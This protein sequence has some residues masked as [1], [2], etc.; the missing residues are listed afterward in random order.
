MISA[1]SCP[2]ARRPSLPPSS[3]FDSDGCDTGE[4]TFMRKYR[5]KKQA[6]ECVEASNFSSVRFIFFPLF[7]SSSQR[8][9]RDMECLLRDSVVPAFK[10]KQL[11]RIQETVL[12][13]SVS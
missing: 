12:L 1:V 8:T 9:R 5:I 2:I 10:L 4:S 7:Y 6:I 3:S 11:N 13:D